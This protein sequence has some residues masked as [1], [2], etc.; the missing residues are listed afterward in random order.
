MISS[1][2]SQGGAKRSSKN[3]SSEKKESTKAGVR[4]R[5]D[6]TERKLL[7]ESRRE[8]EA[9]IRAFLN[10]VPEPALLITPQG[11]II[12]I[13]E[14]MARSL[15]QKVSAL[16]GRCTYNFIEPDAARQR[17]TMIDKVARTGIPIRFED[18]RAGRAG[19]FDSNFYSRT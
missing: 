11:T 1:E 15:G 9:S 7:A 16:I 10:A 4:F 18:S 13:N 17:K 8:S 19:V 12:A 5:G 6:V 2:L 3:L 14:I